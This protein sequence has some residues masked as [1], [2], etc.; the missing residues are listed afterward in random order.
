MGFEVKVEAEVTLNPPIA[1]CLR[2]KEVKAD[3]EV[4]V[5]SKLRQASK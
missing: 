1:L 4:G 5:R 3:I 2:W